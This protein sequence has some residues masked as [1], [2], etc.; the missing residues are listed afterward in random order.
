MTEPKYWRMRIKCGEC[1]SEHDI[2]INMDD[3][4]YYAM[5]NKT[6]NAVFYPDPEMNEVKLQ[7]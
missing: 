5:T 1:Q 6:L 7:K 3:K 4:T 2:L